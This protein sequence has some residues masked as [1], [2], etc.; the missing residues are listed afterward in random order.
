MGEVTTISWCTSTFNPVWGC[1]RVSPGC[2]AC[3]AAD[4]DARWGGSHW[5]KNVPRRTFGDKHWNEPLK[6]EKEAALSSDPWRVFCGSM[7]DVMDDEWPEGTRE[8]LWSLIDATP[9]LTWQLLTKRP[10][11]YER[12]LP[13][14]GFPHGNVW[15]GTSTENQQFYDVRWPILRRAAEGLSLVAF[16]SYEPALGPLTIR[17]HSVLPNWI[18]AGSESGP[19]RRPA[20]TQWY[21]SLRDECSTLGVSFFMKQLGARTPEQGAALIPESLLIRQFPNTHGE[22]NA[23]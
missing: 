9:H 18:I 11:R 6:W 15:L 12:Y 22:N 7:C 17:K 21:E 5:G 16:I 13:A 2:N 4:L 20:E 10:H 1:T 3:F 14:N 23:A 19:K 8:R